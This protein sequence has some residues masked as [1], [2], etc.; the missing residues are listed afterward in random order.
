MTTGVLNGLTHA[1]PKSFGKYMDFKVT[2]SWTRSLYQRVY[3]SRRSVTTS[4]PVITKFLYEITEKVL[5]HSIPDELIINADQTP[6][7]FA[8]TDNTTMA[9]KGTKHISHAG[10]NDKRV[11]TATLVNPLMVQCYLFN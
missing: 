3:F 2:R 8:T 4:R 9:A 10:A 1:N 5:Q 6:S 7:K 11:I